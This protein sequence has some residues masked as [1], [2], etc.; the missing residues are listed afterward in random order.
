MGKN[1]LFVSNTANFQKFNQPLMIWL[2][3][4]KHRVFYASAGE[5]RIKNCQQEFTVAIDR[6]PYS[7]R[8][9]K[10]IGQLKRII[11]QQNV[12][13]IHCHTPMGGVVARIANAL[14][15]KNRAKVIYTAHGFHFYQGAPLLNWLIYYPVEKALSRFTDVLITIN[16]QDYDLAKRKHFHGRQLKIDGVGVDIQRFKPANAQQK[17]ALR[18]QFGFKKTDFIVVYV[19]EFIPRKNHLMLLDNYQALCRAVPNYKLVLLGKGELLDKYRQMYKNQA[20]FI[21]YSSQVDDYFKLAD[22]TI[23]PSFQEGLPINVIEAMA[24][25]L[26]VVASKIRGQSDLIKHGHNGYLFDLN[27][28]QQMIKLVTKLAQDASL[29]HKMGRLNV[30]LADKYSVEKAVLATSKIYQELL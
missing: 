20:E 14:L 2:K 27:N 8:N 5:E 29:R 7:W 16:Q 1:I 25:G 28:P 6:S 21:G 9:F 13:L 19:A 3:Q 22:L 10:A 24:S 18:K 30:K 15:G 26:P 4:Q 23:C 11:K 17:N 12:D